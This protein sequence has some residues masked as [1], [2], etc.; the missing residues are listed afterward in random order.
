MCVRVNHRRSWW[1]LV[2]QGLVLAALTN[3]GQ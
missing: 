1:D 3:E 2:L